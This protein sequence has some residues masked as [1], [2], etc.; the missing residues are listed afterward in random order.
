MAPAKILG[1]V[2]RV[3]ELALFCIQIDDY[4]KYHHRTFFQQQ[5]ETEAESHI[6]ELD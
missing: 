2:E 1:I 4:L 3:P 5:M 6:R